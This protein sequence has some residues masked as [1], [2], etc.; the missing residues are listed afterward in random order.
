MRLKN[1]RVKER[2]VG[3]SLKRMCTMWA[4][5]TVVGDALR[6][7]RAIDSKIAATC[8]SLTAD[9]PSEWPIT[10]QWTWDAAPFFLN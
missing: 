1:D 8:V 6:Y 7:T 9:Q 2:A 4:W 3:M 5:A 10:E